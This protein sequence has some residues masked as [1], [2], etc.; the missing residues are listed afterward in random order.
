MEITVP[1]NELE[2]VDYTPAAKDALRKL[3]ENYA[4]RLIQQTNVNEADLREDEANREITS[5]MLYQA[6]RQS[7]VRRG[8]SMQKKLMWARIGSAFSIFV[9]GCLFDPQ[10]FQNSVGYMFAFLGVTAIAIGTTIWQ[11]N[12]EAKE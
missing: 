4:K 11:C 2:I 3:T 9:A 6:S 12:I 10:S 8:R 7:A 1:I 5:N